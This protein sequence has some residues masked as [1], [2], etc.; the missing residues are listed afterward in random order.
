L[1]AG[2]LVFVVESRTLDDEAVGTAGGGAG[3]DEGEQEFFDDHGPTLHVLGG[4]DQ[5]E[6]LRFDCFA[7]EPHYHYFRVTEGTQVLCR[8]D[9]FAQGDPVQ[10]AIRC[11]RH[12]LPEM[13]EYC[14]QG[15]LAAAVRSDRELVGG[16]VDQV[17]PLLL[18]A[19][20]RAREAY[21]IR[22]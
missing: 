17:E 2:P 14:G 13:L 21:A 1:D 11:V 22:G 8:V 19:R 3:A 9:Q 5:V 16:V 4:A 20:D 10:W 12:Q 18:A 6:H 15:A 7:G